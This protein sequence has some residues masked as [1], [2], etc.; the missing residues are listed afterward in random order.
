VSPLAFLN[1]LLASTDRVPWAV[2]PGWG[3]WWLPYNYAKHGYA[4]DSLFDWIFWICTIV[5]VIVQVALI[6]FLIKYRSRPETTGRKAKFIHGNTKLEMIWTLIPAVILGVIALASKFV[7]DRYRYAEDYDNSKQ[8]K[9][10]VIG[11]QFKWNFVYPG[12][13]GRLGQYLAFPRP[14]DPPF[15]GKPYYDAMNAI[16]R[17]ILDNPLGQN[18]NFDDPHNPDAKYGEDDDYDPNPG[19]PL[20][21]PIDRPIEVELSSKD[22]IHD[23]FL[24]NF[25]VKLDA[26]PGMAGRVNFTAVPGALGTQDLSIDDPQLVGKPIWIDSATPSAQYLANDDVSQVNYSLNDKSGK[27]IVKSRE[28]LTTDSI[29]ALKAA[30]VTKVTAV[31]K[32]FELVCE[33]LCGQ[34][35]YLMRAEIYFV[36]GQQYDRFIAKEDPKNTLG[37]KSNVADR[38]GTGYQPVSSAA[39]H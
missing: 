35:H 32:P 12:K 6:Y 39:A 29:K 23:F 4:M 28:L 37:G 36:S 2:R 1:A 25:R 22:V 10:L 7:W 15:R 26:L 18:K 17:A 27:P 30:G 5:F 3:R 8:T 21:L 14:S 33:E 11:E 9:V 38:R 19:R 20:I 31:T 13:D 24:P 16:K 34:G